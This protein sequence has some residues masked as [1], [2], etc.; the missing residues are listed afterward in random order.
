MGKR[1]AA[2]S[3]AIEIEAIV[4]QRAWAAVDVGAEDRRSRHCRADPE[5]IVIGCGAAA[6]GARDLEGAARH[7]EIGR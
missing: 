4:V 6:G 2:Q 1:R 7:L 3:T 5:S